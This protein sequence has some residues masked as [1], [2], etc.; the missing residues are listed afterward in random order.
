M[1]RENRV[2]SFLKTK[3]IYIALALCITGASAAAWLTAQNASAQLRQQQKQDKL[4][5]QSQSLPQN[6]PA[7]EGNRWNYQDVLEQQTAGRSEVEKPSQSPSLSTQPP[8]SSTTASDSADAYKPPAESAVPEKPSFC[9]PLSGGEV[10]APYSGGELVKNHTLNVWRTHDGIDL[11]AEKGTAVLA[12]ADG[13][14]ASV[15]AD[16]L[17]GGMVVIS[18][19]G[20][21]ETRYCGIAPEKALKAGASVTAGQVLG[22]VDV[23]ACE[24]AMAPHLH[25]CLLQDGKFIDPAPVLALA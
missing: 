14:V 7:Q 22:S 19:A 25:F 18:H 15:A 11:A 9:S 4:P 3:G 2:W 17:W 16:P 5:Q 6:S 20:G 8:S 13:T 21:Y 24:V 12:A 10:L 1:N 23:I